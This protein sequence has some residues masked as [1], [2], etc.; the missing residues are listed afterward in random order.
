[1]KTAGRVLAAGA[2]LLA[3]IS[4]CGF[5]PSLSH[6]RAGDF[7]VTAAPDY[8]PLAELRGGERFP[9]GAHLLIVHDGKTE[10]LVADFAA[11]AD[12]DVSYDGKSVLFAG[13]KT[14]SDPWQIWEL[15]LEDRALRRVTSTADDAERPFHLPGQRLVWAQRTHNGFQLESSDDGRPKE[16]NELNPTAGPGVLPLTYLRASAFPTGVLHDGRI[17]FESGFPLGSGSTPE[18]FLIYADGSGVESYRCDHGTARWGASQLDSGDVVFTHGDSL[19]RFTSAQSHE[20]AIAAPPSRYAG[21]IAEADSGVWLLS[22]RA[23]NS[24]DYAISRWQPGDA[25]HPRGTKLETV[26]AIGGMNLVDPVLV[27]PHQRPN[28]HPSGLH[29]WNYANLMALDVRVSRDGMVRGVPASV[30]L[31]TQDANGRAVATGIAPV[32][33]DGSF[34]VSVPADKP[35]R[36]ALLDRNG[37]VLRQEHGWFWIRG[38]EQRYC[39]GC[40]AGPERAPENHVPAVLMRTTTPVD[41]TGNSPAHPSEGGQ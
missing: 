37:V 25:A 7:I 24:A 41:L 38:G 22:A 8:K 5:S 18:I 3:S 30:R 32:E 19:A 16:S 13:K 11:S 9:S 2:A 31:E 34:F 35:I 29:P 36:F 26:L 27:A 14:A 23:A 33:Q 21:A 12:A 39:V 20:E 40:H 28:R 1:M 4:M 6:D 17:L 15:N 10:P